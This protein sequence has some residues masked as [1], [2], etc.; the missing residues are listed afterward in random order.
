MYTLFVALLFTVYVK[1]DLNCTIANGCHSQYNIGW[2]G[3]TK[4][5][6]NS[7]HDIAMDCAPTT[8]SL[9]THYPV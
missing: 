1:S 3:L 5:R 9:N 7:Y 4:V 2:V 8:L 6:L